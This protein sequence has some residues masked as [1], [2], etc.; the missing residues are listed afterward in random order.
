MMSMDIVVVEPDVSSF[1]NRRPEK[2]RDSLAFQFSTISI[3][4]RHR[5]PLEYRLQLRIMTGRALRFVSPAHGAFN[6]KEAFNYNRSHVCR[7]TV[8]IR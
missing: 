1:K 7:P 5:R 2:P 4:F 3:C 8:L 6:L